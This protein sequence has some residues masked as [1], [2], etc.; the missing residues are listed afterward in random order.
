MYIRIGNTFIIF[1]L[2]GCENIGATSNTNIYNEGTGV[3]RFKVSYDAFI[4]QKI[5]GSIVKDNK[6]VAEHKIKFKRHK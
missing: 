2:S 6:N 3:F 5:K 4:L 1:L